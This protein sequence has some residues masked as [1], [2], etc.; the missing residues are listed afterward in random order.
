MKEIGLLQTTIIPP[1]AWKKN[2]DRIARQAK[3]NMQLV[4][5]NPGAESRHLRYDYI[6]TRAEVVKLVEEVMTSAE[7]LTLSYVREFQK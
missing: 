4:S 3:R 7:R 2:R 1:E 6:L 5:S